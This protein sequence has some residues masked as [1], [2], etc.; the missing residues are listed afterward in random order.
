MIGASHAT[1]TSASLLQ[2]NTPVSSHPSLLAASTH[3]C[4]ILNSKHL[5]LCAGE[6]LVFLDSHC[7]VNQAWLQPLLA[8]IQKDRRTVVCP[9]IDIISADT[10][11][12][13]P[14][15][16]VRGGF[17][18]GLHFKWDPVPPSEINGFEGASGPIRYR[19]D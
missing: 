16:I 15:P 3:L 12:Y 2:S 19:A 7:E 9:V 1:G 5:C 11:A 10:L 4:R 14:S 13:S 17:N 6:V 8:P 18:W